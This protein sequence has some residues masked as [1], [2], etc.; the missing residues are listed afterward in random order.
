MA[1]VN[2]IIISGRV[3]RNPYVRVVESGRTLISFMMMVRDYRREDGNFKPYNFN[4]KVVM[5][6]ESEKIPILTQGERI[7]VSG[8][9]KWPMNMSENAPQPYHYVLADDIVQI[10]G[11]KRKKIDDEHE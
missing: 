4:L 1:F 5:T 9:L 6:A 10:D 8:K 7:I 2:K 3:I 11:K